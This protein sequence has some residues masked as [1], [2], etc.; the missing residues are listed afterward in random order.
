MIEGITTIH[1]PDIEAAYFRSLLDFL[2]SGQTCVPATDVEH[3]HDLLDLLQIKPGVWRT[4]DKDGKETIEVLTRIFA[5]NNQKLDDHHDSISD[6]NSIRDE[7]DERSV[8]NMRRSKSR[9]SSPS[10]HSVKM[11]RLNESSCD[12]DDERNNGEISGNSRRNTSVIGGAVCDDDDTV[13][14]T[15][16]TTTNTATTDEEMQSARR[17]RRKKFSSFTT[18]SGLHIR[19]RDDSDDMDGKIDDDDDIDKI[20]DENS[21][22]EKAQDIGERRRS[23]SD[24]V[25]LS[26]GYRERDEDSNDGHIDV[27]TI[28]NAPSKVSLY[29]QSFQTQTNERFFF[30]FIN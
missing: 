19:E 15:T 6:R 27:E 2:Y 23:S 7:L 1:F 26:L 3:L 14:A 22:D 13:N 24:P 11:E 29:F 30:F 5:E 8:H 16:T 4:G 28:G 18:S 9:E 12:D 17:S 20:D 25:N 21:N 10:Q